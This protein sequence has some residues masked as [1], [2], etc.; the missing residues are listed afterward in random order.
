MSGQRLRVGIGLPEGGCPV[1]RSR[2]S[3]LETSLHENEGSLDGFLSGQQLSSQDAIMERVQHVPELRS[4]SQA[5][6]DQCVSVDQLPRPLHS[7]DP[8][9]VLHNA[10]RLLEDR[11]P[12]G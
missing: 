3:T 4:R 11:R 7:T 8:V 2:T 1:H 6:A 9:D 5:E 12:P 10:K